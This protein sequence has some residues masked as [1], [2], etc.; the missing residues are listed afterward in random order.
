MVLIMNR[1]KVLLLFVSL[2]FMVSLVA[3]VVYAEVD[4]FLPEPI[5]KFARFVFIDLSDL[6]K[7]S[8]NAFIVYTKIIFFFLVFSVFYWGMSNIKGIGENKRLAGVITF[9]FALIST[10]MIPNRLINFIFATYSAVIGFFFAFLPFII[11]LILSHRVAGGEGKWQRIFRGIIYIAMAVF[12]FALVGTLEAFNDPLY[13]KVASWAAVGAFAA[14]LAGIFA[15]I[16]SIGG[17]AGGGGGGWN[18]LGGG[19]TPEDR[20]A[21][22]EEQ[23]RLK[24][25]RDKKG[26]AKADV[27]LMKL[28][29]EMKQLEDKL[30][31]LQS[32]ELDG[33]MKD[34]KTYEK[35]KELLKYLRSLLVGTWTIDKELGR[36]MRG[37]RTNPQYYRE[38]MEGIEESIGRYKDF[39]SRLIQVLNT[40]KNSLEE[41]GDQYKHITKL[42]EYGEDLLKVM[43]KCEKMK[44]VD[45]N[46]VAR[47][48]TK[49]VNESRTIE[50]LKAE[51]LKISRGVKA[52]ANRKKE[53]QNQ[54]L[55]LE[56]SQ[57]ER[58]LALKVELEEIQKLFKGNTDLKKFFSQGAD[59]LKKL[60]DLDKSDIKTCDD[61]MK[62][63]T[64]YSIIGTAIEIIKNLGR[65]KLLKEKDI[66]NLYVG[67]D[68]MYRHAE[69]KITLLTEYKNLGAKEEE[70][71]KGMEKITDN[72]SRID[73]YFTASDRSV[74]KDI[75][76]SKPER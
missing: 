66:R 56:A 62:F 48:G 37:L 58:N 26:E 73:E 72:L 33:I 70:I 38:N 12:T 11:G 17:G 31:K 68:E 3:G 51:R 60:H 59:K 35:H 34:M 4:T 54:Q 24:E 13:D 71:E 65:L 15:L 2:V 29:T 19:G 16:G 25:E 49:I 45:L 28:N 10:I 47:F 64:G 52:R 7:N 50:D 46:K 55:E 75:T 61:K 27:H 40:L 30:E 22:R 39:V 44:V 6:A 43:K 74:I 21:R 5:E 1:K 23:E 9:L 20:A 69:R 14:L 53:I 63:L 36:I 41:Q 18:P 67:V 42:E 76:A 32:K 8:E 57:R